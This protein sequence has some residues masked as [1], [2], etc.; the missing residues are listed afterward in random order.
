M[1]IFQ[2]IR[3]GAGMG[4]GGKKV[5]IKAMTR[6][7]TEIMLIGRPHPPKANLLGRSGWLASRRQRMQEMLHM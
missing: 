4:A 1:R 6:N 5:K 7:M 2:F 3:F